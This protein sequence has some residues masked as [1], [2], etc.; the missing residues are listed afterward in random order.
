[1]RVDGQNDVYVAGDL[2]SWQ[3]NADPASWIDTAY[4]KVT[5]ADVVG[6]TLAN[7]NGQFSFS[8]DDKGAW[9]M[10]GLA[11]GEKLDPN[12]ITA[13]VNR[14]AVLRMTRPLGKTESADYGLAKPAA[15]VTLKLKSGDATK[16]LTLAVGAKDRRGQRLHRQVI[17]LP[18]LREG[19]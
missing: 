9:Q 19:G 13:V 7:A 14:L 12:Q 18:V 11:A 8:K 3:L 1:M 16:T 2:A 5:P 4:V 6:F 15:L 10:D 17:R